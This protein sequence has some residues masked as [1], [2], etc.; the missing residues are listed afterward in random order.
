M[1]R[2]PRDPGIPT[3]PAGHFGRELRAYRD[4]LGLTRAG[5][6]A[7]LGYSP[8]RIGQIEGGD[9]PSEDF[10]KDCDAFFKTNGSFHRDWEWIQEITQL[11]L[12]PPGFSEYLIFEDKAIL[13]HK[14]EAMHVT[15]LFQTPEYAFEMLKRRWSPEEAKELVATRLAR[16][17]IL[18]GED[19][20]HVVVVY[21]EGAIRRPVGDR[22]VMRGQVQH[23]ID[24]AQKPN[25]TLQI[26]PSSVG[27]YE[28]T[29]GAFTVLG[30]PDGVDVAYEEGHVGGQLHRHHDAV[31]QFGVR[32]DLIRGVALSA[33][34]SLKLLYEILEGL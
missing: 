28:G 3:T 1:P 10:A 8:Q 2:R 14:F 16:Q 33:E 9:A 23:L 26:V 30:L 7:K 32:F 34:D 4:D 24:M 20:C 5:L 29:L 18:D 25:V 15:G 21:D 31:R 11:E 27:A 6:A 13:I 17:E 22:N 19:A 12:L